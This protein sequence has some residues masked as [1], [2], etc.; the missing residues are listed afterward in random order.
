MLLPVLGECQTEV[1]GENDEKE[2]IENAFEMAEQNDDLM[3]VGEKASQGWSLVDG[4]V[5]QETRVEFKG[6]EW[7]V[8]EKKGEDDAEDEFHAARPLLRHA[9]TC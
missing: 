1:F 8:A 6:P 5:E 7:C 9:Q 4:L 3:G 2:R